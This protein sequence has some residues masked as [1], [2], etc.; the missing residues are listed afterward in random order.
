MSFSIGIVGLPN[1]GKSTLFKALTKKS[2]LIANYPFATIDPNVGIVEVPDQRLKKLAEISK[3]EKIIPT[4]IEFFDIAGLVK[5][6]HSGEGLGNKF[7]ANIREVDAIVEVVRAFADP[8]VQHVHGTVDPKNDI[9]VIGL[10]LIMADLKTIEKKYKEVESSARGGDQQAVKVKVLLD[11]INTA[12]G[13]GQWANT[14]IE[15]EDEKVLIKDLHLLTMKPVLYAYNVDEN[16]DRG[17]CSV[18]REV[19]CVEVSAKIEAELVELP[20]SEAREMMQSLGMNESG[21][22]KLIVASYKLLDLITF[23]TS[24]PK[25]T[26]AWTIKRGTKAPQAASVIH[27]DFEK[28]FVRAEIIKYDDFVNNNGEAGA[29]EKGLMRVEGKEYIV[30]D[31]DVIYFRVSV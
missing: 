24:G 3:S 29:K 22:D 31:G 28:G 25:E 30:Q 4:T 8:D 12:L 23:L 26:R 2:V 20:E 21:L 17:S 6:A 15:A 5:G 27:T 16:G 14:V 1:V 13:Q 9:E 10:E 11:K 19:D 18:D 7:L